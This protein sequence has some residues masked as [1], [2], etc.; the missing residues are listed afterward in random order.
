M[1]GEHAAS[2]TIHW[3]LTTVFDVPRKYTVS[4]K[5]LAANR[6][7]LAKANA[8]P[9]AIRF[10]S[11]ERRKAAARAALAAAHAARRR[12]KS[13][14]SAVSIERSLAWAGEDANDWKQH[15][16]RFERL[17]NG[18][19]PGS[20]DRRMSRALAE[21]TW[22]RQRV[23]R[24]GHRK[25]VRVFYTRLSAAARQ[26]GPFTQDQALELASDLIHIFSCAVLLDPT[27]QRL[28]RR[29]AGLLKVYRFSRFGD[30]NPADAN[31][32]SA[33][34]IA[35]FA[36]PG[37]A[38]GNPFL[39][40]GKVENRIGRGF[41]LPIPVSVTS[42][43]HQRLRHASAASFRIAPP[44]WMLAD[45]N[46]TLPHGY[47]EHFTRVQAAFHCDAQTPEAIRN[48][49]D[50]IARLSWERLGLMAEAPKKECAYLEALLG[51]AAP[52][53]SADNERVR[54]QRTNESPSSSSYATT[55]EW[56]EKLLDLLRTPH[57]L[58]AVFRQA[59]GKLHDALARW[60]EAV[61]GAALAQI[62]RR[63][64]R[65]EQPS[66]FEMLVD[67]AIK[68]PSKDGDAETVTCC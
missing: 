56:M 51:S 24:G 44:P 47:D 61:Y 7:N 34:T 19:N 26:S 13:C 42:D 58:W 43:E 31:A 25:E 5:V 39:S 12:T 10:R 35:L 1:H 27:L 38:M 65:E 52:L 55:R 60:L 62:F 57:E 36:H 40:S 53:L 16:Q 23:W 49:V 54:E 29:A 2:I 20:M 8:V 21:L 64:H 4:D 67:H 66:L 32:V 63:N 59:A 17:L 33:R 50:L 9:A 18:T 15:Q 45:S 11:T 48:L 37:E 3:P 6:R 46:V 14:V 30:F 22:R 68:R 41:S 28:F